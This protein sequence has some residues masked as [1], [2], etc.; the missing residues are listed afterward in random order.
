[1]PTRMQTSRMRAY[2]RVY[3]QAYKDV[4][5]HLARILMHAQSCMYIMNA[6]MHM[7]A[8]TAWIQ[9]YICAW[10]YARLHACIRSRSR[11]G[12]ANRLGQRADTRWKKTTAS[13]YHQYVNGRLCSTYA[14]EYM[15][16][17]T[18]SWHLSDTLELVNTINAMCIDY[19][20][21]REFAVFM[22]FEPAYSESSWE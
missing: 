7:H 1:M 16:G 9:S 6:S 5:M 2:P 8:C 11:P 17:V 15:R 14:S 22:Q 4:G 10:A 20:L 18:E 3:M 13:E 12:Q 21:S 19:E